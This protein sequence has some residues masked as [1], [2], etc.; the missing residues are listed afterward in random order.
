MSSVTPKIARIIGVSGPF[1]ASLPPSAC[2]IS[3]YPCTVVYEGGT[4]GQHHFSEQQIADLR[5]KEKPEIRCGLDVL[6]EIRAVLAIHQASVRSKCVKAAISV[7]DQAAPLLDHATSKEVGLIMEKVSLSDMFGDDLQHVKRYPDLFHELEL[8]LGELLAA[9]HWLVKCFHTSSF[10][11]GFLCA[12]F[13]IQE[14]PISSR[15][16]FAC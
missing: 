11:K 14:E 8:Q 12:T 13:T 16:A 1:Q 15:R 6:K 9:R 10:Q 4:T 5:A 7:L 3:L 2:A